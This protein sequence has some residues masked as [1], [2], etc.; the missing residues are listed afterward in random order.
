L[1]LF[2]AD[3]KFFA[4]NRANYEA[5]GIQFTHQITCLIGNC[6]IGNKYAL[7]YHPGFVVHDVEQFRLSLTLG[8]DVLSFT[9]STDF[10]FVYRGTHLGAENALEN[11]ESEFSAAGLQF[12]A[13]RCQVFI[14]VIK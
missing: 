1:T 7:V 8:E 2:L 13:V 9:G 11:I 5:N 4:E 10:Q 14:A 3:V 12:A 6:T